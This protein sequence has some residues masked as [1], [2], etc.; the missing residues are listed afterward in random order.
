M[1]YHQH[2]TQQ[3][4]LDS[5]FIDDFD[6]YDIMK[7]YHHKLTQRGMQIPLALKLRSTKDN[8]NSPQDSPE[9]LHSRMDQL[10]K[11][12]RSQSRSTPAVGPSTH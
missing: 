11:T 9:A 4:P 6:L 3:Q 12:T 1:D 8:T 2:I 5:A 7:H 10:A